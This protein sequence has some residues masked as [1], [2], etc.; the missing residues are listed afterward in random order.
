MYSC[1]EKQVKK[2]YHIYIYIKYN[3][4]YI[5][6]IQYRIVSAVWELS[7]RAQTSSLQEQLSHQLEKKLPGLEPWIPWSQGKHVTL[8][9]G[10]R[11]QRFK[12]PING[13]QSPPEAGFSKPS[14]LQM[15]LRTRIKCGDIIF[16]VEV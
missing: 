10:Q 2:R 4:I 9:L 14:N 3:Y 5:Y 6:S 11:G 13:I 16:V 15:N 8:P 1:Q 7:A 12:N